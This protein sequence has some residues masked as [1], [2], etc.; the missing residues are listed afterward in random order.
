M[1]MFILQMEGW[2]FLDTLMLTFWGDCWIFLVQ[3]EG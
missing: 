3:G 2:H 1:Q